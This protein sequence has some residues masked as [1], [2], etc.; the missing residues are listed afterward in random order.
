MFSNKNNK[1]MQAAKEAK[2]IK[3]IRE[4]LKSQSQKGNRKKRF[5]YFAGIPLIFLTLLWVGHYFFIFN[6]TNSMPIG[7]YYKAHPDSISYGDIVGICLDKYKAKLAIRNGVLIQ[8]NQCDGGADMLIKKVIAR[9]L[10]IVTVT[11]DEIT[12]APSKQNEASQNVKALKQPHYLAPR[13]NYT[14]DRKKHK[15]VLT[16]IDTGEYQ[17]KGYWVYGANNPRYSWDSRY[18]GEISKDNIKFVLKPI[19]LF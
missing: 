18:F 10:D 6:V 19:W 13:F 15:A 12:V 14:P 4:I 1:A 2:E 8:N 3:E 5:F 17:S 7:L 9:P 11:T 16:F